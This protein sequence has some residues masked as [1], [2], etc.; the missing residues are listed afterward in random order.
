MEDLYDKLEQ[1]PLSSP[2]V[3]NFYQSSYG[4]DG[5]LSEKGKVGPEFQM[6]NS[7]SLANY[8]NALHR[9][10]VDN[11]PIQYYGLFSGETYKSALDPEFNYVKDYQLAKDERLGEF[12]DK[13]NLV[14]AQGRIS[15][16]NIQTIKNTLLSLPITVDA[17]GNPDPGWAERR[18]KMGL[19]LIMISPEYM[20]TK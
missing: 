14:L 10:I 8:M 7:L 6:L 5:P 1:R 12:L 4:P 18:L 13:Y 2:S 16:H 11:S 3:F 20:I 9:W 19:Y 17:N 15:K